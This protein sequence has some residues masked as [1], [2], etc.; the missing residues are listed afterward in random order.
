MTD[1]SHERRRWTDLWRHTVW[2]WAADNTWQPVEHHSADALV[3]ISAWNPG[4]VRLPEAVNRARDHL[5]HQELLAL[6]LSP[7]RVRGRSPDHSWCEEAW[8]IA[9]AAD[10]TAHLLGRYGQIAGWLTEPA[11]WRYVW[12][13]PAA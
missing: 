1:D 11:G 12:R 3:V 8:Q 5:L 4:G 7:R 2:E 9:H 6:G 10:R 13:G